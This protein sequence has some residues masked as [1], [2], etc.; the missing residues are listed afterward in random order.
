MIRHS[1]YHRPRPNNWRH[2]EDAQQARTF[3]SLSLFS[4]HLWVAHAMARNLASK[5]APER[6]EIERLLHGHAVR[7]H[8]HR[9]RR[10]RLH[11][12][13]TE[14]EG[15]THKHT[16]DNAVR[17]RCFICT[18]QHC[19][20]QIA[21]KIASEVG[22]DTSWSPSTFSFLYTAAHGQE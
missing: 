21:R 15:H 7:P 6:V 22:L 11:F 5:G 8:S 19:C 4:S 12:S 2:A 17:I 10:W 1:L 14:R 20:R 16:N 3:F 9:Q 18:I 13:H